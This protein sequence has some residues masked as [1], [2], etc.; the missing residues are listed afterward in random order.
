MATGIEAAGLALGLFPI[1][2]EGLK[3]YIASADAVREMKRHKRTLDQFR[4]DISME[5]CKF[6]NTWYTLVG[7]AG[8]DLDMLGEQPWEAHVEAALISSLPAGSAGSFVDGCQDLNAILEELAERFV[9]YEKD[10]VW[11]RFRY[12]VTQPPHGHLT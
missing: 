3:F 6:E 12:F 5:K 4:R 2:L 8:M 11:G 10:T 9:K 7:R 1:V